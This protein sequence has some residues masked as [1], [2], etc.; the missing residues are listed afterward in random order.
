MAQ[1]VLTNDLGQRF[2]GG[3]TELELKVSSVRELYRELDRLY[4]GISAEL[5]NGS[6]TVAIDGEIFQEA[7]LQTIGP[8]S[9]VF[10]IPAI[11]GG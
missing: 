9:E 11:K 4:P 6:M 8:D 2:A 3:K 10:F 7:L 5:Q 1:V